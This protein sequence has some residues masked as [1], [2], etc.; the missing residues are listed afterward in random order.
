V[1]GNDVPVQR[2]VKNKLH[3]VVEHLPERDR[4]PVK[5]RLRRAWKKTDHDR[6]LKRLN[7][8]AV[9]LDHAQP[10]AAASLREG[11]RRR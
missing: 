10:G 1:F 6:A 9:E 7:T 2:S 5:L 11:M 4:E 3:H 8:L